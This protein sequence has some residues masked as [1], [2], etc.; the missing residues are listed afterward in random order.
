MFSLDLSLLWT[1]SYDQDIFDSSIQGA[2]VDLAASILSIRTFTISFLDIR[3]F[4]RSHSFIA[5]LEQASSLFA[6]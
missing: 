4:F 5:R 6:F 3:S 2:R 1:L